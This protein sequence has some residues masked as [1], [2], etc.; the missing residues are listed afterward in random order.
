M[1]PTNV[2]CNITHNVPVN[3]ELSP[4][5]SSL[6]KKMRPAL[7][8]LL[9]TP[10]F[11]QS[12]DNQIVDWQAS[13][14]GQS[15]AII[16]GGKEH[17]SAYAGQLVLGAALDLE[18]AFNWT[19]TKLH[20][21]FTDR[22]GTNLAQRFI[23]SSTS[24][25]ETYGGGQNARLTRLSI[26]KTYLDGD[27]LIEAGRLPASISFL[28]TDVCQYFQNNATCG[29]PTFIFRTSNISWWPV[30]SWG[31]RTQY[32]FSDATYF[33]TGVFEENTPYQDESD[34]GFDW[35]INESTG[36]VVPVA[37]GYKTTFD[38]DDYPSWYEIG[39]YYDSTEY[40]EP[41]RDESG[42]PA[43][44]SGN[45][46][47]MDR[48][49]S[50]IFA[51]F[52]Q[53]VSRESRDNQRGLQVFGDVLTGL[54]GELTE[55]YFLKFGLLY[56]GTFASRDQDVLGFVISRQQYSDDALENVRIA[57]ALNGGTGTPQ[58]SMTMMEFSYGYQLNE[59]VQIVPNL[60]YII[61]PDQFAE[62]GRTEAVDDTV[63]AG[64]R[65]NVDIEG[66]LLNR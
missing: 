23:G 65:V 17:G 2:S 29:N 43:L 7:L 44:L 52:E 25:Q 20:V 5:T 39:G 33:H 24:V 51:R 42:Q 41:L 31:A 34:H 19:D 38:N 30:S 37:F 35:S 22:H 6:L 58:S 59:H 55:S 16:D 45:D 47:A 32:W 66:L 54:S 18:Q 56:R 36:V 50:G 63:V 14:T 61:N 4:Q 9:S 26:E 13:Y 46:Y 40:A 62:P 64:L 60:H 49:R 1:R 57:R 27:L 3:A 12:G 10:L 11:A 15:A 48:G 28:V 53:V 21:A 8:M